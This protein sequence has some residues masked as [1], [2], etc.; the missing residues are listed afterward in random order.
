MPSAGACSIRPRSVCNRVRPALGESGRG[1]HQPLLPESTVLHALLL[2]LAR[3]IGPNPPDRQ[4]DQPL[5]E[6]ERLAPDLEAAA[7]DGR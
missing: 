4:F 7:A 1:G 5:S 6:V 2:S 3:D